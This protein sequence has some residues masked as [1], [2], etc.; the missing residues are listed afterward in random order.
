MMLLEKIGDDIATGISDA[1]VDS[2]NGT[3]TLG[4]AARSIINNLANDLLRLGINTL[5]RSSGTGLFANLPGLANGGR[6]RRQGVV[7]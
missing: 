6:R 2:I 5:L 3:R 1:L 7:I 4:E